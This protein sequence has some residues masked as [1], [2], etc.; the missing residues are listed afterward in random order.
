MEKILEELVKLKDNEY[1]KFNSKLCPD[2]KKE[3]LGIRIPII[4]NYAKNILKNKEYNIEQFMR[5]ENL[6]YFEEV[7]LQGFV[8]AYSKL[9][10]K[11]KL[12]YIKLFIPKIDSWAISDSFVPALKIKSKNL[13]EYWSFILPYSKSTKEFEIR[14]LVISMLDYYLIDEYIDKVIGIL[15]NIKHDG[16]YVKMAV[17][18]TIAEIGVKFNEKAIKI[19]ESNNLDKFTHNKAIQKMI[20]SY[21]INDNQKNLLRKMK[22]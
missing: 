4:R 18:W 20:E 7:I 14:F 21:R 19:L 12:E 13:E 22:K 10:F 11:E 6:E 16:Y 8:I 15:K 9:E 3:M 17:A 2:T 5:K 1:K